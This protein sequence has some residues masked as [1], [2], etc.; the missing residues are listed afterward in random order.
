MVPLFRVIQLTDDQF[1]DTL[2]MRLLFVKKLCK[3]DFP[4]KKKFS[5][6]L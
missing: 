2:K 5:F 3:V 1:Y 4:K 6:V